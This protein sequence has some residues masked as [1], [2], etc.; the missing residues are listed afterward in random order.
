[1]GRRY[2]QP[3]LPERPA[4]VL[5]VCLGNIC[6][7]PFA[8]GLAARLIA[9]AGLAIHC[10]SAGLEASPLASSPAEA[11][12]AARAFGVSLDAHRPVFLSRELVSS[13]DVVIAME[14]YQVDLLRRRWPTWSR[15]YL[16]LSLFEPNDALGAFERY[17]VVDPFGRPQDDYD[18][19]FSRID[20]ALRSLINE[21]SARDQ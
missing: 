19:C 10:S 7:S 14:P 13:H 5:F 15:R 9:E 3:V 21:W 6:R 11:I 16:L 18:R 4:S 20:S 12:A 1:M 2:R 17:H 8:E